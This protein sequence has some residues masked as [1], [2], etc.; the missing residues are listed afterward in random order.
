MKRRIMILATL[1]FATL[2]VVVGQCK[3]ENTF[4]KNGE[5]LT[6]DMYFKLGFAST[7]AGKLTLSVSE[8][9]IK[10][11][12][13]HKMKFQTNTSGIANGI[14]SVHDTLYAY[15]TK[16]IVPVAYIKNALESGDFTQEELYYSYAADGKV[17]IHTK[18]NKNGEFRFDDK[19]STDGCIYDMVSVVYYA[20]TLDFE[21][22]KK[23]DKTSINFISGR[24][25]SAVEIQYGGTKRVKANDGQKYDT[26]ELVLNFTAGGGETKGKEMMKVYISNDKNRIPIEINTNLKKMGAAVRGVIKSY[27]GLKNVD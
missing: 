25:I 15:T 1:L 11:K 24:A 12:G 21:N 22:M 27:K 8:G 19:L 16:D 20:R 23:G 7:K 4:F 5:E 2:Q 26:V 3:V 18:R 10:G 17:D 13:H 6:Y 14:Y 9:S